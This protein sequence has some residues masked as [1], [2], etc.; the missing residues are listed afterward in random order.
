MQAWVEADSTG[1][2]KF[3]LEDCPKLPPAL[4]KS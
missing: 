2:I 3:P 1:L 4:E